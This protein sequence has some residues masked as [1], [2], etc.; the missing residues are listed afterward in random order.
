MFGLDNSVTKYF[1]IQ[2]VL[3]LKFP[4]VLHNERDNSHFPDDSG[5]PLTLII[6]VHV[7]LTK[8]LLYY[9]FIIHKVVSAD[10]VKVKLLSL[11]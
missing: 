8:A 5:M 4:N 1:Q 11:L 7:V 10:Q 6:Q 3:V 2:F 9:L